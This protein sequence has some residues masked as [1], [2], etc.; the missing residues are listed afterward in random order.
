MP[1]SPKP[2]STFD[3]GILFANES[4][5]VCIPLEKLGIDIAKEIFSVKSSCQCVRPSVVRYRQ[6][7]SVGGI[8][9]QLDFVEEGG[10]GRYFQRYISPNH[11]RAGQSRR[12]RDA[13][14]HDSFGRYLFKTLPSPKSFIVW[15]SLS[16][17]LAA[18][19]MLWPAF[20]L[21]IFPVDVRLADKV[22]FLPP[23]NPRDQKEVEFQIFNN[24]NRVVT[25][26]GFQA[27]CSCG[28]DAQYG[29]G[30]LDYFSAVPRPCELRSS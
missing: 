2:S 23:L 24:S 30:R 26:I 14:T 20:A 21:Q 7:E 29:L 10:I 25:I 13:V 12:R 18:T 3:A 16:S 8:A 28:I 15:V 22:V 11:F 19:V 9:L 4:S 6:R 27:S 5:Y 1:N 17:L